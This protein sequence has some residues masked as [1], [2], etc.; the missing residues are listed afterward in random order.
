MRA[1]AGNTLC[2]GK[3]MAERWFTGPASAARQQGVHALRGDGSPAPQACLGGCL[4]APLLRQVAPYALQSLNPP[5]PPS[6]M[7]CWK[8]LGDSRLQAKLLFLMWE[9]EFGGRPQA[10]CSGQLC[11][12]AWRKQEYCPRLPRCSRP[13]HRGGGSTSGAARQQKSPTP[14]PVGKTQPGSDLS[15]GPWQTPRHPGRFPRKPLR[16]PERRNH[17]FQRLKC[18]L[19]I[20]IAKS[21][22]KKEAGNDSVL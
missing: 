19:L 11:L 22:G 10:S 15:T 3:P 2:N 20:R 9:R 8:A 4:T 7:R 6:T 14:F 12:L 21:R 17:S 13:W 18:I 1:R 5:P 16:W